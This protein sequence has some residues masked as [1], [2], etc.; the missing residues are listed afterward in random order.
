MKKEIKILSTVISTF[1]I[2]IFAFAIGMFI[3]SAYDYSRAEKTYYLFI[4]IEG[5]LYVSEFIFTALYGYK[6]IKCPN[7]GKGHWNIRH[8][9]YDGVEITQTCFEC[10]HKFK[11]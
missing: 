7:C 3:L 6:H 4:L 5:M 8:S 9:I 10:K 11:L 1:K 2:T